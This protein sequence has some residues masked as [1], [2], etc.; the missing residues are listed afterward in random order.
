MMVAQHDYYFLRKYTRLQSLLCKGFI[1]NNK[2][3]L[4]VN[5]AIWMTR[6]SL[7]NSKLN[8]ASQNLL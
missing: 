5:K 8:S 3:L 1:I 2:E 4:I 7:C 6:E